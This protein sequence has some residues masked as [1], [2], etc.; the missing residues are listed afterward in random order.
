[1]KYAKPEE[2]KTPTKLIAIYARVSTSRQEEDGTIETQLGVL[3]EFS[4]QNNYTVIKEYTDDGWSG[5]ILARPSLDQLRQDARKKTWQAV[6]IR[7]W[8]SVVAQR[9][10]IRTLRPSAQPNC[11]RLCRNAAMRA[12]DSESSAAEAMSTPMRGIRSG[13]CARAAS[14]HAA[15]APPSSVMNSRRF[16]RWNCI[17]SPNGK[18]S[19]QIDDHSF[20]RFQT[21]SSVSP[22]GVLGLVNLS[23][24]AV[25]DVIIRFCSGPPIR[26]ANV[27]PSTLAVT[28][29][30]ASSTAYVP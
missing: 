6:L 28:V 8:G 19:G 7:S 2:L 26:F 23:S 13:C 12:C 17:Q 3:R 21:N 15:A 9:V 24:S 29:L 14:G 30:F 18:T 5:D 4:Q 27:L 22:D 20:A 25:M 1:M 10:S 16:N 11:C